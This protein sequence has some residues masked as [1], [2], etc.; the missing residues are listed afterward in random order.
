MTGRDVERWVA[1]ADLEDP[2]SVTSLQKRL[3]KAGVERRLE[4]AGARQ[5]DEVVIGDRAFEF[6]PGQQPQQP[7]QS[8]GEDR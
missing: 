7:E 1:D 2:R 4:A 3:A 8:E 5:G 6:Y